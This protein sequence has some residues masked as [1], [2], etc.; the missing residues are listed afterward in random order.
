M[1]LSW[2]TGAI[3]LAAVFFAAVLLVKP[4]AVPTQFV[5]FHGIPWDAVDDTAGV[6]P[7][8]AKSGYASPN[9]YLNKS[10]GKYAKNV[11]NPWNYSFVFV[12]AMMGGAA[13]AAAAAGRRVPWR[14]AWHRPSGGS[15]SGMRPGNVRSPSS[16]PGSSCW[17]ARA[18]PAA[19]PRAI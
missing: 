15:T 3:L 1:I 9:A 18:W 6:K 12:L 8:D 7:E 14:N 16:P 19:V 2:K 13:L 11:A 5:I 10:G 4:V 17:T